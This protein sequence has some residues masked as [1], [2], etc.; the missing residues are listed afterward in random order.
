MHAATRGAIQLLRGNTA[1]VDPRPFGRGNDFGHATA[2]PLDDADGFHA[3][4]ANGFENRID[5]VNDRGAHGLWLMAQTESV[6]EGAR[7]FAATENLRY[8]G[9]GRKLG[10]AVDRGDRQVEF[11]AFSASHERNADR[12]KQ[13]LGLL[14]CSR[15]H[16]VR[17][18]AKPVAVEARRRG[19]HVGERANNRLRRLRAH[20]RAHDRIGQARSGE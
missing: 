17:G 1:D 15:F 20:F 4:G 16:F 3:L 18:G 2:N 11:R 13:R 19:Q 8:A 10:S 7:P 6:R 5:A 12:M 14:A 9:V